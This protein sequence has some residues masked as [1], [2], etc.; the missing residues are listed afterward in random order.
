MTNAAGKHRFIRQ[1]RWFV[2]VVGSLLLS[3]VALTAE[4]WA[5]LACLPRDRWLDLLDA[6]LPMMILSVVVSGAAGTVVTGLLV[7]LR[8]RREWLIALFL[9]IGLEVSPLLLGTVL[10]TV[11]GY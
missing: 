3:Q 8:G 1:A 4:A 7:R 5:I 9:V 10:T 2:V 6:F 11:R